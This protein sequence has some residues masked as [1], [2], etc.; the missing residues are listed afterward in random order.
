MLDD[1]STVRF[2]DD[3]LRTGNRNERRAILNLVRADRTEEDNADLDLLPGTGPYRPRA[4]F[5]ANDGGTFVTVVTVTE[6]TDW[7]FCIDDGTG[8]R[9]A[10]W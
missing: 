7:H 3:D 5:T 8:G 2:R 6:V 9:R 4:G 1:R 10:R